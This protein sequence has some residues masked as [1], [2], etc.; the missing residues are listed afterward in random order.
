MDKPLCSLL[1]IVNKEPL[2]RELV[3]DLSLQ[4]S[5][6]YELIE[7]DNRNNRYSSAR[8][9]F[10]E[11]AS[12]AQGEYLVFLHPD[13][14]FLD[15]NALH[16]LMA[17]VQSLNDFGVVGVAGAP[18]QLENGK[19]VILSA[20]VHGEDKRPAGQIIEH[21]MEIQTLDECLFV[22][23]AD[24]FREHPF[25]QA[26]GWHL[27]CVE[28]CLQSAVYGRKNYV[29]PA[30]V[31]HLSDGKSLDWKYVSQLER[32]IKIYGKTIPVINTTVRK[33]PTRGLGNKLFRHYFKIK[34][35][36]KAILR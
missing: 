33:W 10:N 15:S 35:R 21:P 23:R 22:I 2:F 7:I 5:I 18:E 25:S 17:Q 31:W 1:V 34:Q 13:V 36:I 16:D 29:V 14:R 26:T 9:A 12:Q 8:E 32:L 4:Q 20:I 27:Y 19:R 24:W 3:A 30:R 28:Q 6:S 11:A